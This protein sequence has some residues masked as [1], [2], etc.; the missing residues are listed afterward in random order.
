ML[1]YV[2]LD[3]RTATK[4]IARYLSA[5]EYMGLDPNAGMDVRTLSESA[6]SKH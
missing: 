2:T 5:L 1:F 4:F 3:S 6:L